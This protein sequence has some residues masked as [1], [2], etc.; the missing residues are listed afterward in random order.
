MRLKRVCIGRAVAAGA[1]CLPLVAGA[2]GKYADDAFCNSSKDCSWTADEWQQISA[3]AN[4]PEQPALDT[5]NSF[6]GVPAAQT[7]GQ[8]FFF[9]TRFSG[10]ATQVDNLRR[11]VLATFARAPKARRLRKSIWS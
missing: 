9:D 1:V 7:L 4:L 2:C 11:P 3:L 10:P 6:V 5:T 8:K